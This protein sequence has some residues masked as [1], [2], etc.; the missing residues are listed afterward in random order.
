LKAKS[1]GLG[2][3]GKEKKLGRRKIR[4]WRRNCK[5]LEGQINGVGKKMG[6]KK[7]WN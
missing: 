3:K 5:V 4:G 7:K 6:K 1:M 2:E